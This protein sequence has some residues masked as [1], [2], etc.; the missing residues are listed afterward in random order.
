MF[1][2]TYA[3]ALMCL[4]AVECSVIR[5][6]AA[7][8]YLPSSE[9]KVVNLAGQ[10][11]VSRFDTRPAPLSKDPWSAY[12]EDLTLEQRRQLERR[13]RSTTL[14]EFPSDPFSGQDFWRGVLD[15]MFREIER[16]SRPRYG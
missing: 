11:P 12:L 9:D 14:E 7:A 8:S 2:I 3:L 10:H 16:K 1:I 13:L 15:H 5:Q 6:S 4:V